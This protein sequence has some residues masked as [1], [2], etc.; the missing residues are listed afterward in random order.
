MTFK[1]PP[2]VTGLEMLTF[3]EC[4]PSALD[5]TP[6]PY[7]EFTYVYSAQNEI[8]EFTT[9]PAE[10]S[11][12]LRIKRRGVI[13]YEL[14]ASIAL[15]LVYHNDDGRESFEIVLSERHQIFLTLKPHIAIFEEFSRGY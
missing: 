8:V 7:N 6:W 2:T 1:I 13:A 15:D 9:C 10:V 3:F 5:A 14:K 12:D 11:V 4:E